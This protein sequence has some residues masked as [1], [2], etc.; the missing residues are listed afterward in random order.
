MTP[1][2]LSAKLAVIQI[3]ITC[4]GRMALKGP[5]GYLSANDMVQMK[6]ALFDCL[7]VLNDEKEEE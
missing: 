6:Q 1:E 2:E 3:A 4:L 7:E 5:M